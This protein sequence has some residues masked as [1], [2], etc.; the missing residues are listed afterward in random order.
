MQ[1]EQNT[2]ERKVL[3]KKIVYI[4]HFPKE[5]ENHVKGT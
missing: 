5:S 4:I 3:L 1:N 2:F